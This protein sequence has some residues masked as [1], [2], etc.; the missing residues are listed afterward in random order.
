MLNNSNVN[1]VTADTAISDAFG[2]EPV[3]FKEMKHILQNAATRLQHHVSSQA[4]SSN[5][6]NLRYPKLER[7]RRAEPYIAISSNVARVDWPLSINEDEWRLA[8][9][10]S[11]PMVETALPKANT[12]EDKPSAGPEWYHLPAMNPSHELKQ[13]LRLL[14]MRS[15]WD[16]KRHY[17]SDN[18]RPLVPNYAQIGT[19]LEGPAEYYSSRIS[20]RDRKRTF[21]EAILAADEG[22]GRFQSKYTEI[23]SSKTSGRRAFYDRLKRKRSKRFP[24][25]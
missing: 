16:P 24:R 18:G 4:Y 25:R 8:D 12:K 22:S 13:D 14:K 2:E 15:T 21:L 5:L 11:P 9:R 3:T 23:Q 20:K 10:R 7:I 1:T 19:I 6:S 17:K